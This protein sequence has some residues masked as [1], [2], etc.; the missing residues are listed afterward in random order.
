[1]WHACGLILLINKA[2]GYRSALN[3]LREKIRN[4]VKNC[5]NHKF[6]HSNTIYGISEIKLLGYQENKALK[7]KTKNP[8]YQPESGDQKVIP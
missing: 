7:Y 8:S 4:W 5:E 1:M 3:N 2:T 6:S